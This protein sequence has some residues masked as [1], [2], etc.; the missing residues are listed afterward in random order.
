MAAAVVKV[1]AE[2]LAAMRRLGMMAVAAAQQLLWPPVENVGLRGAQ[3]PWQGP[4]PLHLAKAGV[5]VWIPGV[6]MRLPLLPW[7]GAEAV[8][9]AR[10]PV[11]AAD[12]GPA[13]LTGACCLPADLGAGAA[14][15]ATDPAV[16]PL[17]VQRLRS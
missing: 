17:A 2:H 12:P 14:A 8:P 13:K 10:A 7:A 16:F 11:P 5:A 9:V 3:H 15:A 4:S 1:A 6:A